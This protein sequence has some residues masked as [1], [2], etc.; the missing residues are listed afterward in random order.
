MAQG[1]NGQV[2][3]R[4]EEEEV[5]VVVA[6][7]D[8]GRGRV[9]QRGPLCGLAGFQ[10]PYQGRD[11]TRRL[12]ARGGS[13]AS[14]RLYVSTSLR[15]YVFA[16]LLLCFS[17]SLLLCFSASLHVSALC[18]CPSV[19]SQPPACT[20]TAHGCCPPGPAGWHVI[21]HDPWTHG[22]VDA[23]PPGQPRCLGTYMPAASTLHS[24]LFTAPS[25]AHTFARTHA[26]AACHESPLRR[27][28]HRA[29]AHSQPGHLHSTCLHPVRYRRHALT[30]L[31]PGRHAH[32]VHRCQA[33]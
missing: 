19:S 2:P 17:A 32:R 13:A 28:E 26:P 25:Y 30:M 10:A 5:V 11:S 29:Q 33:G 15:L 18:P 1:H 4:L 31:P 21:Q 8:A 3:H 22:P 12:P 24:L 6:E 14:L 16:S 7:R 20:H 9:A 27:K 23:T